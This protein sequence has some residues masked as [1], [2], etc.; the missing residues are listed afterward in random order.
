MGSKMC[1]WYHLEPDVSFFQ[2]K[3][4]PLNLNPGIHSQFG[5]PLNEILSS[6]YR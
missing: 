6:P 2:S 1:P 5:M 4:I 3:S